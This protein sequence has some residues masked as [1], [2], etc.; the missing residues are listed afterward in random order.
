MV[1]IG[2][3]F[4][5][6][7]C[8]TIE[9]ARGCHSSFAPSFTPSSGPEWQLAPQTSQPYSNSRLEEGTKKKE[10]TKSTCQLAFHGNG[11][12]ASAYIS[13]GTV[14]WPDTAVREA[15]MCSLYSGRSFLELKFKESITMGE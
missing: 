6:L 5:F 14:I 8:K 15:G 1:Y 10:G 11:H 2:Q 4:I 7:S 9:V 3:S 12:A 13:L